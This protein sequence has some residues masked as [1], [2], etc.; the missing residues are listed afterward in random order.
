[1]YKLYKVLHMFIFKPHRCLM[2]LEPKF[3]WE[4]P[5]EVTRSLK[6]I[7]QWGDSLVGQA[8]KVT[9]RH[10]SVFYDLKYTYA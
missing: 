7:R 6:E 10:G 3:M 2:G 1:M 9:R 8:F 4:G 5:D